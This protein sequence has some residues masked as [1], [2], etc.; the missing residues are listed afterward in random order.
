M[1][2]Y[3]IWIIVAIILFNVL[4]LTGYYFL[5]KHLDKVDYIGVMEDCVEYIENDTQFKEDYGTPINF[6]EYENKKIQK[7]KD[8]D[9]IIGLLISFYVE[10]DSGKVYLITMLVERSED[11]NASIFS[12]FN[13]TE[14][15]GLV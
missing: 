13:I 7:H 8:D 15:D 10:V 5:N 1:K 9:S 12:Y 14:S 4:C 6:I 3:I 11:E 2:K